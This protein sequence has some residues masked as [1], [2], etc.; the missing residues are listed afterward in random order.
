MQ[1]FITNNNEE[2]VRLNDCIGNS[3]FSGLAKFW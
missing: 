3:K 2:N 1:K